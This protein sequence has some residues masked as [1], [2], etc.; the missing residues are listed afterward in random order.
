MSKEF[1]EIYVEQ[2]AELPSERSTGFVFAG[3]CAVIGAFYWNNMMVLAICAGLSLSFLIVSLVAPFLL[4]PLNRIWFRFSL[5]LN[6]VMNPV[7]LGLMFLIAIVP[8]GLLMRLMR[9]PLRS[10][11]SDGST[12]WIDREPNDS[13]THSMTNQF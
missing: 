13:E 2:E 5:L 9:D 6:R 4:G 10:K 3:V 1:H 7:I 8:I 12:Y 11:R